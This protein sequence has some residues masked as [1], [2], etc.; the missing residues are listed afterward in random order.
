MRTILFLFFY[1]VSSHAV[2]DNSVTTVSI[3]PQTN[4]GTWVLN[5][6]GLELTLKQLHPDQVRAFYQARGFSSKIANDIANSCMFQSIAKNTQ[7]KAQG[8]TIT[9]QLKL[10]R[11]KTDSET[12]GIKLKESWNN[13]WKDDE[14]TPAARIA[15][16]WATLPT[17]QSYEPSGDYN[18]GMTSFGLKPGSRF[19]LKVVWKQENTEKSAWIKA[20]RC[21]TDD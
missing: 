4:P 6:E 11:V 1:F 7:N 19:D 15:F 13:Q 5:Q 16:R 14:V 2:A 8:H 3:D 10:W 21:A 9:V 12:R 20:L 18:W 17:E